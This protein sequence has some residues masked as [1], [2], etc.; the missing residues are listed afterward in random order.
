MYSPNSHLVSYLIVSPSIG[1][2]CF[3]EIYPE[4]LSDLAGFDLL[5][6]ISHF[7][8]FYKFKC[9]VLGSLMCSKISSRMKIFIG[10]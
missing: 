9:L 10:Y 5:N 7:S 6:I 2:V 1:S 8:V 4:L 3:N